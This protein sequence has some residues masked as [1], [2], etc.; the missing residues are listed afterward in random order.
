MPSASLR[1]KI[2]SAIDIFRKKE[3]NV[4]VQ[5]ISR[6][7]QMYFHEANSGISTQVNYSLKFNIELYFYLYFNIGWKV[8]KYLLERVRF[9]F[10]FQVDIVLRHQ[11]IQ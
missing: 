4:H 9:Q 7:E 2:H 6:A 3:P 8:H 10:H 11:K 1:G 5:R